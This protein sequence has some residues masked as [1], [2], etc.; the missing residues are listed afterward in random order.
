MAR[1]RNNSQFKKTT[2][3]LIA[4]VAFVILAIVLMPN[5]DVLQT[6]AADL[7]Q[8]NEVE[9]DWW[10]YN[11]GWIQMNEGAS[12]GVKIDRMGMPYPVFAGYAWGPNIGWISMSGSGYGAKLRETWKPDPHP[13]YCGSPAVKCWHVD[14]KAWG[15]NIGWLDFDTIDDAVP[16]EQPRITMQSG[17]QGETSSAD[18]ALLKGYAWSPNIG[19]IKLDSNIPGWDDTVSPVL[20]YFDVQPENGWPMPPAEKY[21]GGVYKDVYE[22]STS[23]LDFNGDGKHLVWVKAGRD[24]KVQMHSTDKNT[25]WHD[26]NISKVSNV[27]PLPSVD[28]YWWDRLKFSPTQTPNYS[29]LIMKEPEEKTGLSIPDE[30][31]TGANPAAIEPVPDASDPNH[32][33]WKS[34][35]HLSSYPPV[36]P[37]AGSSV[38]EFRYNVRDSAGNQDCN[39]EYDWNDGEGCVLPL[40]LE[41]SP[42]TGRAGLGIDATL[43]GFGS[44]KTGL[45]SGVASLSTDEAKPTPVI[46]FNKVPFTAEYIDEHSGSYHVIVEA[47]WKAGPAWPKD[48]NKTISIGE[49]RWNL[50]RSNV[51]WQIDEKLDNPP[52]PTGMS[53]PEGQEENYFDTETRHN[54]GDRFR[55]RMRMIDNVGN[56]RDVVYYGIV[57][58]PPTASFE[59]QDPIDNNANRTRYNAVD[60]RLPSSNVWGTMQFSNDG[61]SWS[62]LEPFT[63]GGL[64]E[65][66]SLGEGSSGG[67]K[68]VYGRFYYQFDPTQ[69]EEVKDEIYA[70]WLE[71]FQGDVYG[72]SG[73]GVRQPEIEGNFPYDGRYNATYRITSG[74]QIKPQFTSE[75]E[76]KTGDVWWRQ[77]NYIDF[78]FPGPTGSVAEID[79]NS[80][81]NRAVELSDKD[82]AEMGEINFNDSNFSSRIVKLTP[83]FNR[84]DVYLWSRYTDRILI[85]GKGTLLVDGNLRVFSNLYYEDGAEISDPRNISSLGV[86]VRSSNSARGNIY[87]HKDVTHMVGAYIVGLNKIE[88][89]KGVDGC[90]VF[91]SS[92]EFS[93]P[94]VQTFIMPKLVVSPKELVLDGMVAA[95]DFNLGRY[96]IGWQNYLTNPSLEKYGSSSPYRCPPGWNCDPSDKFSM[97]NPGSVFG[98]CHLRAGPG[99]LFYTLGQSNVDISSGAGISATRRHLTFSGYI[100]ASNII[101]GGRVDLLVQSGAE[102]KPCSVDVDPQWRR[103]QCTVPVPSLASRADVSIQASIPE[104]F[105]L[106]YDAL[107]LE[108][109]EV[110]T[111]WHDHFN[112]KANNMSSERFYYDGRV[113]LN[114]PP[115]LAPLQGPRWR[116]TVA[117]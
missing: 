99:A 30:Y 49:R 86:I 89:P 44:L 3:I 76:E 94:S 73:V 74:G 101:S 108:E 36:S 43:P 4:A 95:R 25:R 8:M 57:T 114:T 59:L 29:G 98:D 71:G 68:T 110:A 46:P 93:V 19:W 32:I 26:L 81:S 34:V 55:I 115:G 85:K 24:F 23:Q 27:G 7:D 63:S 111:E 50:G 64:R 72:R 104:N 113:I 18:G 40:G 52:Y 6:H 48:W 14:G 9:G 88:C 97:I 31:A 107:Q 102:T 92:A 106:N 87:V 66:W 38:Y 45:N 84:S 116:E 42:M 5:I 35:S 51:I 54:P 96:S 13:Y 62:P 75:F 65:N 1:Q 12:Y 79:W 37:F 28:Y 41:N 56:E 11:G 47:Q 21:A 105:L 109:G 90:G 117:D 53:L 83:S 69:Y 82:V 2:V 22:Y 33:I 112:A 58:E 78:T 70:P 103:F 10:S 16:A 100:K 15:W 61:N 80:L 91:H 39:P 17:V 60:I 67:I 77:G 20:E